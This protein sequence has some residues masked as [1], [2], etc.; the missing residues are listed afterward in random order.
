M[1]KNMCAGKNGQTQLKTTVFIQWLPNSMYKAAQ[2][3]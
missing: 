2:H 1:Y 3:Y